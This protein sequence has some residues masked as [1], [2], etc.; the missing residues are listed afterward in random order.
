MTTSMLGRAD[1]RQTCAAVVLIY[2]KNKKEQQTGTVRLSSS[3]SVRL[4]LASSTKLAGLYPSAPSW[5]VIGSDEYIEMEPSGVGVHAARLRERSSVRGCLSGRRVDVL[6]EA[7]NMKARAPEQVMN[8][9]VVSKA[10]LGGDQ[11]C[12]ESRERSAVYFGIGLPFFSHRVH[13]PR[14]VVA[15]C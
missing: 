10:L 9:D 6:R 14:C 1:K 7:L 8:I 3:T 13:R 11:S 2:H 12:E 15:G 4:W 5:L